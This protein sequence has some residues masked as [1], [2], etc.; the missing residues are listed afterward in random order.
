MKAFLLS[1]LV[2]YGPRLL[3]IFAVFFLFSYA[4]EQDEELRCWLVI[5]LYVPAAL[6]VKQKCTPYADLIREGRSQR[7]WSNARAIMVLAHTLGSSADAIECIVCHPF[8]WQRVVAN[9][10]WAMAA[11]RRAEHRRHAARS[12]W[13]AGQ[14]S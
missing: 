8:L 10:E 4:L 6:W 11:A 14:P 2:R 13:K 1:N 12:R 7:A 5:A 9:R 3:L